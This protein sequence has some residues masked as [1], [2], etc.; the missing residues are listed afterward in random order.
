MSVGL[1]LEKTKDS[2][3]LRNVQVGEPSGPLIS[4]MADLGS[5]QLHR[6]FEAV[7]EA[8]RKRLSRELHDQIGQDLVAISLGLLS[9]KKKIEIESEAFTQLRQVQ[10]IVAHLDQRIHDFAWELR[11]LILDELGLRAALLTLIEQW[12]RRNQIK[13]A[14]HSINLDRL[15][16]TEDVECGIYRIVQE[17]LTNIAKH[18]KANLVSVTVKLRSGLLFITI[19]DNGQGFDFIAI[20]NSLGNT[21]NFG[22]LGMSERAELMGGA[23][24][25]E[26]KKDYGT[27]III[28]IPVTSRKTGNA[29]TSH[30]SC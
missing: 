11:P 23:I 17:S 7:R 26:S 22:I 15:G 3:L 12:A 4:S 28:S 16:L 19:K 6:Q 5:T 18:S 25:I 8:E 2:P 29:K 9:L 13:A 14:F 24:N 30:F 20:Q 1:F 21:Q 27:T 10:E